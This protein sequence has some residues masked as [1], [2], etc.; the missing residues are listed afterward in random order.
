MTVGGAKFALRCQAGSHCSGTTTTTLPDGIP[1]LTGDWVVAESVTA[2]TCPG[3]TNMRFIRGHTLRLE[4]IG[5]ELNGCLDRFDDFHDGGV[6]SATGFVLRT[7]KC[8]SIGSDEFSF[9]Y[10]VEL[11]GSLPSS[12]GGLPV[13]HRVEAF[14]YNTSSDENPLCTIVG[15]GTMSRLGT[16]CSQDSHCALVD[17]CTRCVA[18]LCTRLRG[19]RYV[20]FR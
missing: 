18:N 8:C 7:G 13:T 3:G 20:P 1:D 19:C 15:G 16:L 10:A 9:D 5:T 6:V 11:T 14:P 4:Q 17:A 12:P 2:D